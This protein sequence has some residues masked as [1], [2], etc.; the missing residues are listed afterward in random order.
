MFLTALLPLLLLLSPLLLF[1]CAAR[2]PRYQLY[3][4]LP[5]SLRK[6]IIEQR[7]ESA[8][9][10]LRFYPDSMT[11]KQRRQAGHMLA[12]A[13][14]PVR[15]LA[16]QQLFE[17]ILEFKAATSDDLDWSGPSCF[18]LDEGEGRVWLAG[19]LGG[20]SCLVS[21]GRQAGPRFWGLVY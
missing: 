7:Q 13:S 9:A 6:R 16:G 3:L 12:A 1:L 17:A 15:L 10:E 19:C 20:S 4:E 14:S 5:A 2:D 21:G 18:I 11:A 8:L